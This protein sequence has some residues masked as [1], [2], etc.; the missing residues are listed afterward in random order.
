MQ[1]NLVQVCAQ[2]VPATQLTKQPVISHSLSCLSKSGLGVGKREIFFSQ[3]E[4]REGGRER[5]GKGKGKKIWLKMNF[6]LFICF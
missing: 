2:Q 5:K 3:K 4:K 6:H 1:Q